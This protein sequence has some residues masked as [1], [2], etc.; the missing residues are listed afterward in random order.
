MFNFQTHIRNVSRERT[1]LTR[2]LRKGYG[3]VPRI[4]DFVEI[5]DTAEE[6]WNS[7]VLRVNGIHS[8]RNGQVTLEFDTGVVKDQAEIE[9]RKLVLKELRDIKEFSVLTYLR[10]K[11]KELKRTDR[12]QR[13]QG[14]N[15]ACV[16]YDNVVR[17]HNKTT[18][19]IDYN[20][21]RGPIPERGQLLTPEQKTAMDYAG[22]IPADIR[23]R[24]VLFPLSGLPKV[25]TN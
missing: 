4:G 6:I 7:L 2:D 11:Q 24:A 14:Y 8:P 12:K 19:A 9:L 18:G 17:Y 25:I 22:F 20:Y 15:Y 5:D 3:P 10:P 21:F 23:V 1:L 13:W 16:D